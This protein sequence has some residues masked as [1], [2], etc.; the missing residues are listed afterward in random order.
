MSPKELQ[1]L[2]HELQIKHVELHMQNEELQ[3][4][5]QE[6]AVAR[7]RY[8]DLYDF[9]P[10]GYVTLSLDGVI[11]EANLT[12]TKLLGTARADLVGTQLARFI[13]MDGQNTLTQHLHRLRTEREIC[14]CDVSVQRSDGLPMTL[15][16]ESVAVG[17]EH[18]TP[19][20][21]RT[22]LSEM[23]PIRV[24][25][26]DDHV[27]MRTGMRSWLQ[28]MSGVEVVG[29][30]SDG[31]EALHLIAKVQP[32]VVLMDV[33]RRGL[34]GLEAT[35][36]VT[37]DFPRVHV[38]ILSMHAN[39]EYVV[40]ALRAGASGYMLKD[41]EPE[42]LELALK[43]VSRDKTYLSPAVSQGVIGDY[44]WRIRT[45]EEGNTQTPD[46]PSVLTA[47]QREILQLIAEGQTTKKIAALLHLSEK[48]VE[49][50][51]SRLMQ[52]LDI[53][54]IAGLM[55]YAICTGLVMPER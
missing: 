37:K 36:R 25:L 19:T 50:H 45:S 6:L 32:D 43:A 20:Q 4:A 24:L 49:S 29:E 11:Q 7:D 5:Q 42:E 9:A 38:L 23:T 34:Y 55:R 30:A 3:R 12:A 31:R 28:S 1:R 54:D 35:L 52:Q 16:L 14:T 51:R 26:A 46:V 22:I 47:R 27:L 33:G 8:C 10:V 18:A 21:S 15:K 13:S 40:H 2:V 39:E 41:A 44:L 48:T 17:E 53:H